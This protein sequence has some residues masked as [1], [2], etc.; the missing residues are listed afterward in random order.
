MKRFALR[1]IALVTV[2]AL[3]L[4]AGSLA[5]GQGPILPESGDADGQWVYLPLVGKNASFLSPIIP[6]TTNVLPPETT[7]L[8]SVSPDGV[9]YTFSGMTPELAAVGTGEIIV[10][11]PTELAPNGFLR[12]VTSVDASGGQVILQTQAATLEEAIEQGE[13]HLDRVLT[14]ADVSSVVA[15]KGVSLR[16]A[17]VLAPAASF[18]IDIDDVVLYEDAEGLKVTVDGSVDV[19][20]RIIIDI[21]KPRLASPPFEEIKIG[22]AIEETIEIAVDIKGEFEWI[23]TV[24]ELAR[25]TLA[26]ITVPVGPVPVVFSPV[27]MVKTGVDG[28]VHAGVT[29]EA[30]QT[31]SA[32]VGIQY[33]ESEWK[34]FADVTNSFT[35]LTPRLSAGGQVKGSAPVLINVFLYGVVGP[36][37]GFQAYLELE[38]DVFDTPRW[39]L[40]G[41]LE[42]PV[43]FKADIFGK[44]LADYDH[45]AFQVR[46]L[47]AQ[48]EVAPPTATP[49]STA[50][51]TFTPTPTATATPTATP[52]GSI[53]PVPGDMVHVPAGEFQMGCDPDHNGGWGC[54]SD[55][56]PLHIVY[57][58]VFHID[59]T[60]VTNFQYAR[61]VAAGSCTTP[62]L[63]SSYTRSSYYGNATYANYPVIYVSWYQADA[64]CRWA[65]KRLPTEAEWEKAARGASDTRAYPWGDATP[66][67]SLAN[68]GGTAGCVGDTSAVGSYPVGASPFGVF[69]MAGNVWEWVNDWWQEHYYS[70]SPSSN[71]TGPATGSSRVTRGGAWVIYSGHALRAADRDPSFSP[72]RQDYFIGFR[73]VAALGK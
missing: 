14:P 44:S 48:E 73:C 35:P 27:L 36:Y 61:C 6:E 56:L 31:A 50:T 58:D 71:P 20:P 16:S 47:I 21:I 15:P 19:A 18:H 33:R 70:T 65:G 10:S 32:S 9:T 64:Y 49:T 55:E 28:T 53:T 8:T 68:H 46:Q 67:C 57:L 25:L 1:W 24:R 38:A 3:L 29:F 34:S 12:K 62:G 39:K 13:I 69:D 11:A 59:R 37:S 63:S 42:V 45:I 2:F 60:E 41:G 7:N 26:P 43:G 30:S 17:N 40:Y 22:Y 5:A 51:G 72:E 52:T 4:P 66:T 23:D 54:E